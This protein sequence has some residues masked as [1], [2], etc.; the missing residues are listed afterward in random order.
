MPHADPPLPSTPPLTLLQAL[1]FQQRAVY[2]YERVLGVDHRL[3]VTG[4]IQLSIYCQDADQVRVALRIMYRA[5]YLLRLNCAEGHPDVATCDVRPQG[6]SPGW[7]KPQC[8]PFSLCMY[9]AQHYCDHVLQFAKGIG[10]SC[11]RIVSHTL[12]LIR[13]H[14]V[15]R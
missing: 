2:I 12:S 4:Y 8:V 11:P 7:G 5:R 9:I 1:N 6:N 14:P 3:T 15:C 10:C 13:S